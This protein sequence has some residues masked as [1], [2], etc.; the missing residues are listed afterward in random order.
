MRPIFRLTHSRE[1]SLDARATPPLVQPAGAPARQPRARRPLRAL[2]APPDGFQ[3][4]AR[5]SPPA[6]PATAAPPPRP[7]ALAR[8]RKLL[9]GRPRGGV[10]RDQRPPQLA[11]VVA[12][13]VIAEQPR[14]LQ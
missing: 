6:L 3:A 11:A 13:A 8:P 12:L 5:R 14:R 9:G 7:R 4:A 10:Q 1:L 2:S